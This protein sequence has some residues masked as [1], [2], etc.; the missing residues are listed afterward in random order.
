MAV[1]DKA[2]DTEEFADVSEGKYW[3]RLE[4]PGFKLRKP[5][6]FCLLEDKD[7][8]GEV[9][10]YIAMHA[11]PSLS[12][13]DGDMMKGT[14]KT[15]DEA[16]ENL[17]NKIRARYNSCGLIVSGMRTPGREVSP[18]TALQWQYLQTIMVP[19]SASK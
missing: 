14:G 18:Q 16:A 6:E 4:I 12:S 15:E 13:P 5:L 2:N 10:G 7:V 1:D 3:E 17:V 11:L 9:V 19:A 8:T